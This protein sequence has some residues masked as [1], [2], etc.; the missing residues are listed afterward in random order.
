MCI[1]LPAFLWRWD[2]WVTLIDLL[3]LAI[4]MSQDV[5][6]LKFLDNLAR[7]LPRMKRLEDIERRFSEGIRRFLYSSHPLEES[8][9]VETFGDQDVKALLD[10][11]PSIKTEEI[12][13]SV[14]L[15][16]AE[17]GISP[18]TTE[19]FVFVTREGQLEP[20]ITG[21]ITDETF[22]TQ[23]EKKRR[24]FTYT[25]GFRLMAFSSLLLL[26]DI[27]LHNW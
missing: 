9:K 14:D 6:S 1:H 11:F 20:F 22:K 23:L 10:L 4:L 21:A 18:P 7:K 25:L 2:F 17:V 15:C 5:E 19:I 27:V 3:G 13:N 8:A 12:P 16:A 26:F 24:N